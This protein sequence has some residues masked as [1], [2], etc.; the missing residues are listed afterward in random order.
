MASKSP[1][2]TQYVRQ[3]IQDTLVRNLEDNH[4]EDDAEDSPSN[5]PR[6][7]VKHSSGSSGS[8]TPGSSSSVRMAQPA[9][10]SAS[11]VFDV[12]TFSGDDN[13]DVQLWL[14]MIVASLTASRAEI[15]TAEQLD[16]EPNLIF[17]AISRSSGVARKFIMSLSR[18]TRSRWGSFRAAVTA[19][20]EEEDEMV[21]EE[22]LETYSKLLSLEQGD[23][24]IREYVDE[25]QKLRK[26]LGGESENEVMQQFIKGISDRQVEI[27]LS[28]YYATTPKATLSFDS[29]VKAAL[30]TEK[31]VK[32]S[33]TQR[34]AKAEKTETE[35]STILKKLQNMEDAFNNAIAMQPRGL[36]GTSYSAVGTPQDA[37]QYNGSNGRSGYN[38]N[39]TT[40]QY[41]GA[42]YN[43]YQGNGGGYGPGDRNP[44][45]RNN[46][47]GRGG[48]NQ[49]Y[50]PP[51]NNYNNSSGRDN[52]R[53]VAG[54]GATRG[55]P[56]QCFRC[57]VMGHIAPQ[58]DNT[59]ELPRDEQ[60]KLREEHQKSVEARIKE[61]G[62][63]GPPLHASAAAEEFRRPKYQEQNFDRG[64]YED[65][66]ITYDQSFMQPP[67]MADG[68]VAE[69]FRRKASGSTEQ[70]FASEKR[71]ASELNKQAFQRVRDHLGISESEKTPKKATRGFPER[72][73]E[74]LG[75]KKPY[76][77][78]DDISDSNRINRLEYGD[79]PNITWPQF[80]SIC[81]RARTQLA[82]GLRLAGSKRQ[83]PTTSSAP[84]V[85]KKLR[86]A[87]PK[88]V[89]VEEIEESEDEDDNPRP[90]KATRRVRVAHDVDDEDEEEIVDKEDSPQT[91]N[92]SSQLG[93][94]TEPCCNFYTTALIRE[95]GTSKLWEV[96]RVMLDSG[97][98]LN[99]INKSLAQVLDYEWKLDDSLFLKTADGNETQLQ[100]F[101]TA[102][103]VVA[104]VEMIMDFYIMSGDTTYDVL[105][106]RPWLKSTQ[107]IGMYGKETYYIRGSR[108]K[109]RKVNRRGEAV[110]V[111]AKDK[112]KRVGLRSGKLPRKEM[113][114]DLTTGDIEVEQ[115]CQDVE[116][117]L[118][119]VIAEAQQ[120]D[121]EWTR[122]DEE[123][124]I[125]QYSDED[126]D[127]GKAK[128]S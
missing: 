100:W 74:A 9:V 71:K 106:G 61:M 101:I 43:E 21:E 103:I 93:E 20:F 81:P 19:R 88:H 41:G 86:S 28:T 90:R 99:L 12:P 125:A 85:I 92:E 94:R 53:G 15:M 6:G 96:T 111:P 58:C 11:M 56:P 29:L 87:I 72:E 126:S 32:K 114:S 34:A 107:A 48:Y 121:E 22:R 39:N 95:F 104:D 35:D 63:S 102:P 23:L 73:I 124:S 84:R 78:W 31:K 24:S 108:S 62:G 120:Q 112:V 44:V 42:Y 119:A 91:V 40:N 33:R 59:F 68:Q 49:Q 57:G 128:H 64:S 82:W 46:G 36:R 16:R 123:Q 10:L 98:T 105:L 66:G 70:A 89:T 75:A 5:I 69:V 4:R 37:R 14:D 109:Y 38:R 97:S 116:D 45:N 50:N 27:S 47:V 8:V 127:E 76:D 30:L 7:N 25:T 2:K 122:Y 54:N 117:E 65:N 77:V 18:E 17:I 26:I 52:N 118:N 3:L 80:F 83:T 67:R 110:I 115:G 51:R 60:Y 13:T 1:T 79:G 55:P 113:L